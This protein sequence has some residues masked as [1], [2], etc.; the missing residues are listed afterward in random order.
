MFCFVLRTIMQ[1]C[2]YIIIRDYL[3]HH[4]VINIYLFNDDVNNTLV[5]TT[6]IINLIK[7]QYIFI[8][9]K[10]LITNSK[11]H[12]S[13]THCKFFNITCALLRG[14]ILHI[15]FASITMQCRKTTGTRRIQVLLLLQGIIDQ[16]LSLLPHFPK[17]CII[18][19]PY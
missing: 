15:G 12:Q 13:R 2:N 9:N 18:R 17:T 10:N 4:R 19:V 5:R 3:Y 16:C 11:L 7:L 1:V 6:Y 8:K 14:G